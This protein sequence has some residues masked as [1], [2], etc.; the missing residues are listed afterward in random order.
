[1]CQAV[2]YPVRTNSLCAVAFAVAVVVLGCKAKGS[3]EQAI[4]NASRHTALRLN[5]EL[6]IK[7]CKADH[8]SASLRTCV[9]SVRSDDDLGRCV[10]AEFTESKADKARLTVKK[11][12]YE[13][14]GEW[15]QAHPDDLCP[16][17]LED[18]SQYMDTKDTKDPWGNSYK[19]F[20]G[21]NLPPGAKGSMA[22]KSAGEDGREGTSDDIN[23]WE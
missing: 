17:K 11:Y 15:S 20:C 10:S 16:S 6:L 14:F 18:L 22:V 3:C 19:M 12:A 21:Q 4:E 23:S 5:T 7:R 13:A 9:A 1:M 8:W 2:V